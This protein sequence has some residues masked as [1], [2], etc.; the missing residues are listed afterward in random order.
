MKHIVKRNF[1]PDLQAIGR[2][3]RQMRGFDLT[4]AQFGKLIGVGQTQ[5]S[6]YEKGQSAPTIE[7]L[8]KLRAHSGRSLDWIVTGEEVSRAADSLPT[9]VSS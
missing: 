9:K 1:R 3:I 4:Q 8:L 2:R 6:K 5:L 7:F